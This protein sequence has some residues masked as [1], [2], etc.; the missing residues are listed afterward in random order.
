[1]SASVKFVLILLGVALFVVTP[2]FIFGDQIEQLFVGEGAL[3]QLRG[4]GNLAWLVAIG[5]L[6]SDLALPVPTT[7][8]MAALGMIYGPVLGGIIAALG[9]VVSGLVGYFLCRFFGRPIAIWLNGTRGLAKGES[10]FGHAG[11]WFVALS[12]WL[13]IISEI[14]ACAAGLSKM[15]F[16]V[17]LTAL[18]CGSIPLGFA[19]ASLGYLGE[20]R[21]IPTLLIAA[22]LP[23]VLWFFVRPMLNQRK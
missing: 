8:V 20:D 6:I 19:Y 3:E 17:F 11:G 23:F 7:A 13:P 9:S 21:P 22:L 15:R 10:V 16:A 14:V 2:F 12:R 4:Y 18:I 5:L 1:M